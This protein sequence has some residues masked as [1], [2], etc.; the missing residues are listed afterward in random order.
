MSID[1]NNIF[2][3]MKRDCNSFIGQNRCIY[4]F[5]IKDESL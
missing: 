1:A 5:N 2:G 3:G 4:S